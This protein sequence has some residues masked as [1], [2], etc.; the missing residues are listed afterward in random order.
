VL[1]FGSELKAL[2]AHP[3][4]RAAT[5]QDAVAL[6]MRYACVP[7]PYSIYFG[8]SKLLPGTCLS[9]TAEDLRGNRGRKPRPY[10]S[11]SQTVTDAGAT[12][13]AAAARSGAG[14]RSACCVVQSRPDDGATSRSAHFSPEAWILH[15]GRR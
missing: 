3:Q 12:R 13:S 8:I 5:D 7:A 15:G 2:C 11:L 9:I 10:W 6:Y 14:A 1:L 4:F